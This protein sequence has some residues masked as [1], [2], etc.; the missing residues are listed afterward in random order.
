[1]VFRETLVSRIRRGSH[2]EDNFAELRACLEI[3]VSGGGLRKRENAIDNRLEFSCCDELHHRVKLGFRA[4]VRAEK[5]EL[6]AEKK[7]QVH[8]GV[9]AG[10]RAA[11]DQSTGG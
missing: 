3:G 4:H 5:R 8:F 11:G 10:G 9:V 7:T 1:M 2:G 6:A